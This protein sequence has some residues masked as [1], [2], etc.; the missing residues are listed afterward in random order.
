MKG[1]VAFYDLSDLGITTATIEAVAANSTIYMNNTATNA[2]T[3]TANT[4]YVRVIV[5][6]GEKA[7]YIAVI[8][9]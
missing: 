3:I 7:P 1:N 4:E 2:Y 6:T 9:L 8:K 5:Q